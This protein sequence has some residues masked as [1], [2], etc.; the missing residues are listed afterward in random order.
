MGVA[1]GEP[2]AEGEQAE[3]AGRE[4]PEA[5]GNSENVKGGE[6][7]QQEAEQQQENGESQPAPPRPPAASFRAPGAF[8]G[9]LDSPVLLPMLPQVEPSP[10]TSLL[11]PYPALPLIHAA[12]AACLP[13]YSGLDEAAWLYPR[14]YIA[15][16]RNRQGQER[17]KRESTANDDGYNWR[18]YGEKQVKGSSYPRSYYKCS[19]PGCPV[20]KIIERD[21]RTGKVS[22]AATK[23]T[24][25]HPRP[26]TTRGSGG[27]VRAR[28]LLDR[29]SPREPAV[30]AQFGSS[31]QL[32]SEAA[33]G[34]AED[35]EGGNTTAGGE[36]NDGEEGNAEQLGDEEPEGAAAALQLLGTGFSPAVPRQLAGPYAD[37]PSSLLPIPP[38]L[39]AASAEP[40]DPRQQQLLHQQLQ[41]FLQQQRRLREQGQAEAG[42]RD[43]PGQQRGQKEQGRQAVAHRN[44]DEASHD[45]EEEFDSEAFD[46]GDDDDA[47]EPPAA[48]YKTEP[49]ATVAA[50]VLAANAAAAAAAEE[51]RRRSMERG[52]AGI[53]LGKRKRK[54]K[55]DEDYVD[56]NSEEDE[57]LKV[58]RNM[59]Q[60]HRQPPGSEEEASGR[61]R[62]RTP[63]M[64]P[65]PQADSELGSGKRA[66]TERGDVSMGG[67]GGG[68][69]ERNTV[70]LETDAD[71]IDDGYRWRKYGQK[72]VKGNLY[73]RSYYKCT[74]PGCNVRKQVERSGKNARML[75][76]TYEGTHSHEAPS[77][78]SMR[79]M[80]RRT[81]LPGRVGFASARP[82][83]PE[84]ALAGSGSKGMQQSTS[85]PVI[86]AQPGMGLSAGTV[87]LAL[88]NGM[89][90][91]L[92]FTLPAG[93][94]ANQV[95][96]AIA[97]VAQLEKSARSGAGL[98]GMQHQKQ[99]QQQQQGKQGNGGQQQAALA[100]GS[101]HG[102]LT[103]GGQLVM[104]PPG[105]R[106]VHGGAQGQFMSSPILAM[107]GC[108]GGQQ[109]VQ[110]FAVMPSGVALAQQQ[111][112]QAQQAQFSPLAQAQPA[113]VQV[114]PQQFQPQAQQQQSQSQQP[115]QA[116]DEK[117]LAHQGSPDVPA[118][119]PAIK[120]EQP[121]GTGVGAA[122]QVMAAQV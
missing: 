96:A 39:R 74:H 24:H 69:D 113:S 88:P 36:G 5:E 81:A 76:T 82:P 118:A 25:N 91:G 90:A 58:M 3:P 97:Q 92:Q 18:K 108:A 49:A 35:V 43:G 80:P 62:G 2:A 9:V 103:A 15:P 23:G 116:H 33:E 85:V 111:V 55:K 121:Q 19:Y 6:E 28:E 53:T 65:S 75:S 13:G 59:A 60:T 68:A 72:T 7:K 79:N 10:S 22:E 105:V 11:A 42:Q 66:A 84:G 47:W 51:A 67:D 57:E 30:S 109:G 8:A 52:A 27:A 31:R 44:S 117:S 12:A 14:N 89:Q 32:S 101:M 40:E 77:A 45:T 20:K 37:T 50:A 107:Q 46:S 87:Q 110:M 94:P 54:P 106:L 112:M 63:G 16:S 4:A 122:T 56:P 83:L 29:S 48:D 115:S 98:L 120:H 95:A 64:T 119:A 38:S 99:Q 21:P 71:N 78:I 104:L 41:Q 70:E 1:A 17:P 100:T 102:A 73:P 114:K 61:R 86:L 93:M 34:L 26:G